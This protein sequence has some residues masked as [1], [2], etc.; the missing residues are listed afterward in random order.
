MTHSNRVMLLVPLFIL[1]TVGYYFYRSGTILVWDDS[2]RL[3]AHIFDI[4]DLHTLHQPGLAKEIT[5]WAFN[6]IQGGYR[7]LS[8]MVFQCGAVFFSDP[9]SNPASWFLAVGFLFGLLSISFFLVARR[10]TK[11]NGGALIAVVLFL[12]SSPVATGSWVV[13]AGIQA[14]VPLYICLGLLAYWKIRENEDGHTIHRVMFLVMLF[15]ILLTG[16]WFREF[17]GSLP[18]LI[19]FLEIQ[20]NKRITSLAILAFIFFL[21]ALFPTALVKYTLFNDIPLKSVFSIGHLG[22]QLG[23]SLRWDVIYHFLALFPPISLGL[24]AVSFF[25]PNT[26]GLTLEIKNHSTRSSALFLYFWLALFLL[27]FLKVFTEQVHLAYAMMPASI[28]LSRSFEKIWSFLQKPTR[29]IKICRVLFTAM[30]I[31]VLGDHALNVYGSYRVVHSIN[32]G[33]LSMSDWFRSNVPK[34]S[35]VICNALHAEDIRLYSGGHI[36]PFWTVSAGIPEDK[37]ALDTDIKLKNFLES[38]LAQ[39]N[40]YFLDMDFNYTPDKM[41]YHSHKYVRNKTVQMVPMGLVH[42]TKVLYPYL[43]PFKAFIRRSYISFLGPPDLENDFYRGPSQE[44][45]P[46]MREVYVEYHVYRVTGLCL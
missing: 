19:L 41:E 20:K 10:F 35:I 25:I 24:F 45:I 39:H 26:K 2:V 17:I 15:F 13:F 23:Q 6:Q 11:T 8:M 38:T 44:G 1:V 12:L 5:S 46:F 29:L 14:T 16:P 27:P 33:I 37:R 4:K 9:S 28:I 43:D 42:T 30:L 7:P 34:N 36:Y 18:I 31:V 32:E 22:N 40:V 21:H 3:A